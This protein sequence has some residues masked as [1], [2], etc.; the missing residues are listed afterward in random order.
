MGILFCE[1]IGAC[2]SENLSLKPCPRHLRGLQTDT[3]AKGFKIEVCPVQP[4]SK[5]A[6][7]QSHLLMGWEEMTRPSHLHST[8]PDIMFSFCLEHQHL[9]YSRCANLLMPMFI[10]HDILTQKANV[11]PSPC[12]RCLKEGMSLYCLGER[13]I[14]R[15]EL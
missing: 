5:S 1:Y 13:L 11:C 14:Y 3:S 15:R 9:F 2:I 10:F 12:R 7:V 4:H 8:H 6:E